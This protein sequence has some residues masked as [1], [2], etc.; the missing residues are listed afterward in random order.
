M[1]PFAKTALIA[2]FVPLSALAA[3]ETYDLDSVHTYPNFTINHL[4][5]ST[6]H[7]Q[8]TKTTG[9]ATLDLAGKSGSLEIKIDAAS[10]STGYGKVEPGS[11]AAKAFGPRSRDEHL[12]TADFFNVA[13][14]P[15]IVY[16]GTK[17]NFNGDKVESIDGTLTLLGVT[18]PLRLTVTSFNCGPNPFSKKDMCGVDAVA[19]FKRSDF[20]MKAMVGPVSD[21][22]KLSIEAEAYKR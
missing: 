21:E 18:K 4:G 16:K 6:I 22:V 11:A 9:T 13:E 7:G 15:E 14:F 3:P 1:S 2:C 12:R 20:G 5:M 19:S 10:V 17:F 8:F